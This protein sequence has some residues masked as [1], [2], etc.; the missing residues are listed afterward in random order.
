M[1]D[2]DKITKTVGT[3][4]RYLAPLQ[5]YVSSFCNVHNPELL[6]CTGHEL[7]QADASCMFGVK[8]EQATYDNV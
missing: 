1:V 3:Q 7:L 5:K 6:L 4:A 2:E 8:T